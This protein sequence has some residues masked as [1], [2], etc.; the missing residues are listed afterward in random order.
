MRSLS[1]NLKKLIL[2]APVIMGVYMCAGCRHPGAFRGVQN[3]GDSI[4]AARGVE[5]DMSKMLLKTADDILPAKSGMAVETFKIAF[6]GQVDGSK[7]DIPI[8]SYPSNGTITYEGRKYVIEFNKG[9]E[10]GG[11]IWTSAR[12]CVDI[13]KE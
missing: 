6:E 2:L 8:D 7:L 1:T 13:T 4:A 3:D 10:A 5:K 11:R 12:S 9:P